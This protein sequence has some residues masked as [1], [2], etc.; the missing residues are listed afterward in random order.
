MPYL[1]IRQAAGGGRVYRHA[2]PGFL[3]K[4]LTSICGAGRP[5]I[6]FSNIVAPDATFLINSLVLSLRPWER[7]PPP[8]SLLTE[9]WA[10]VLKLTEG[11]T[12]NWILAPVN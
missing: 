11:P 12:D 2:L 3:K 4:R 10:S 7:P 1:S 6:V 5:R 8:L 9:S